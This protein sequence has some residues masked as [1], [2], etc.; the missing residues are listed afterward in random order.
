MSGSSDEK[1][2]KGIDPKQSSDNGDHERHLPTEADDVINDAMSARSK[3][4]GSRSGGV[5]TVFQPFG[6]PV[7]TALTLDKPHALS[8]NTGEPNDKLTGGASLAPPKRSVLDYAVSEE[9]AAKAVSKSLQ[10][11]CKPDVLLPCNFQTT[12]T[13]ESAVTQIKTLFKNDCPD[14]DYEF[15][16]HECCFN[17]LY[18]R[19]SRYCDFK[20]RLYTDSTSLSSKGRGQGQGLVVELQRLHRDSCGFVFKQLYETIRRHVTSSDASP[21]STAD[22]TEQITDAHGLAGI[23]VRSIELSSCSQPS[24]E[25]V[26]QSIR[27]VVTMADASNGEQAQLEAARILCDLSEEQE[28]HQQMVDAQC[29]ETLVSMAHSEHQLIRLH[30]VIAL[31]QLSVHVDC[32][33]KIIA[34]G[35][36]LPLLMKIALST[37]TVSAYL[38]ASMRREAARVIENVARFKPTQAMASLQTHALDQFEAWPK[39]ISEVADPMIRDR[40]QRALRILREGVA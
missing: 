3:A 13:V 10:A 12:R 21:V 31:A 2:F 15:I 24:E 23:D 20:L 14:V 32:V 38:T 37:P 17:G 7:M 19:G 6:G 26:A 9:D 30:A 33:L 11:P 35:T 29:L 27:Q 40:C 1:K 25:E 34:T 16:A 18:V 28:I 4:I 5:D 22:I 36:A 39:E 8:I